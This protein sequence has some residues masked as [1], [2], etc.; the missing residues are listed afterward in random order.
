MSDVNVWSGNGRLTSDAELSKTRDD[1]DKLKFRIANNWNPRGEAMYVD[2]LVF[3]KRA[4]AL[5]QHLHKGRSVTLSGPM[6]VRVNLETKKVS[7]AVLADNIHLGPKAK[8][9][10]PDQD[11]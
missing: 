5:H 4:V 6:D 9:D 11:E 7:V 8:Y 1:N 10:Y 2:V 3:G